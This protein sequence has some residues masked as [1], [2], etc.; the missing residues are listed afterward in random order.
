MS[1]R[2][3]AQARRGLYAAALLALPALGRAQVAAP[4]AVGALPSGGQVVA[5]DAQIR[6]TGAASLTIQQTTPRAAIDWQ[7]FDIGSAASVRFEQP[8]AQSVVL[9]RV[10][11]TD[12]SQ[13]FGTLSANGQVFLSNPQGVYFAP[14]ARAD[15]NWRE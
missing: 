1:K 5:G 7:R 11:G 8:S 10:L 2:A 15:L 14:G 3:R 12:P 4:P 9:N 13:I 6:S